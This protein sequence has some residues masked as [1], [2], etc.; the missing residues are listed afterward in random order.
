MNVKSGHA[1][2][3]HFVGNTIDNGKGF[4]FRVYDQA[5][6]WNISGNVIQG[7]QGVIDVIDLR[8]GMR[9]CIISNNTFLSDN[10]YWVN[11]DGTVRSWI[12]AAGSTTACVISNNVFKNA[13]G[14]F[15]TFKNLD[16]TSIVGNV[17]SN[18]TGVVVPGI[19]ITGKATGN[20]II[21]NNA[22]T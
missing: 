7:I 1:Y 5:F 10:G 3:L 4:L 11:A 20:T 6:G 2:G 12:K 13:D 9:N 8:K 19:T 22:T 14:A 18:K 17:M 16:N 15:L 21:G